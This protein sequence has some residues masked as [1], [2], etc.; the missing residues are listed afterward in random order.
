MS[1]RTKRASRK[2]RWATIYFEVLV[3][4][5]ILL[6][7]VLRNHVVSHVP[8]TAAEVSSGPQVVRPQNCLFRCGNSASRWCAVRPWS[9]CIKRLIVTCG[10]SEIRRC[11]WSFDNVSFMIDTSCCPQMSWIR[12]CTRVVI[13]PVSRGRRYFVIHTRCK[14][15]YT[16]CAPRRYSIPEVYPRRAR[17]ESRRLKARVLTLPVRDN[18]QKVSEFDSEHVECR[19]C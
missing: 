7:D 9:H 6:G 11:T 10:G 19:D 4:I 16:V 12:S 18:K 3:L 15:I 8:G 13:S 2:V 14:W 1:S 17:A 5:D